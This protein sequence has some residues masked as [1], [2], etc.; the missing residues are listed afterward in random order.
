VAV[1]TCLPRRCSWTRCPDGQAP[2]QAGGT[3]S[4]HGVAISS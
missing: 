1:A 4:I 3:L 2:T